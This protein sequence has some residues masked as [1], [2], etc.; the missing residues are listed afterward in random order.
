MGRIKGQLSI[1]LVCNFVLL[2]SSC[3][4]IEPID[5]SGFGAWADDCSGIAVAVNQK[6]YD[7]GFLR[8]HETNQRYD[9]HLCNT[10]GD[11]IKTIFSGRKVDDFPSSIDSIDY[12]N[13]K[14]SIIIYSG[15][16]GTKPIVKKEKINLLD[17]TTEVLEVIDDYK[18]WPGR[19]SQ[20]D[21]SICDGKSIGWN[22][23]RNWIEVKGK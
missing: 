3:H 9:L 8:D 18:K 21:L 17:L 13:S 15:T 7:S 6:D 2:I 12:D 19:S 10:N 1:L 4:K 5:P 23:V 20:G 22:S 16:Y 14:G 11:I